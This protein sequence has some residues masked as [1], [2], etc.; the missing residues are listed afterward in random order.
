MS[1]HLTARSRL[2][3]TALLVLLVPIVAA[4]AVLVTRIVE[5]PSDSG[6][7][8]AAA[9][10]IV[11]QNFAFTPARLTVPRGTRLTVTNRDGSTHTLSAKDGT[12]DIGELGGGKS[13]RLT[14]TE[15]GTFAYYCKIHNYMTGTLVVK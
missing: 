8:P 7:A 11:I 4:V 13:A 6:A 3:P 5:G 12:F 1:S 15:P 9:H 2:L 14:L 10:A